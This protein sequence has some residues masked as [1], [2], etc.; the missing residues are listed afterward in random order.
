MNKLIDRLFAPA[1]AAPT[2]SRQTGLRMLASGR[3]L[4]LHARDR[5]VLRVVQGRLWAT[6]DGPHQG[7]PNDLGDRFLG[8]G[9][10]LELFP[11]RNLLI[12]AWDQSVAEPARFSFERAL[13]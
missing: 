10:C 4:R 5:S 8:A 12:E 7:A 13:N 11:G 1:L 2:G 6:F 3:A 9:E